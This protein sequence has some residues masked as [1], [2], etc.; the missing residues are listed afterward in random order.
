MTKNEFLNQLK[1]KI[2][3]LPKEERDNAIE[4]YEN[5][6][7]DAQ[8]EEEAIKNL[9]SVDE[10]AANLII[11][12]GEKK[13][14][15]GKKSGISWL[16]VLLAILSAPI[17]LPLGFAGLTLVFALI[18][19]AGFFI[20]TLFLFFIAFLLSGLVS[21]FVI[22]PA[23][24]LNFQTGCFF[25]G[26]FLSSTALAYFSLKFV[27]NMAKKCIIFIQKSISKL[28]RK[29]YKIEKGV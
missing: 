2:R 15:K 8:S 10:I 29:E 16:T 27:V 26:V 3:A 22:L 28:L 9:G 5:Y 12:F 11:E 18:I 7:A 20:F 25:L 13:R 14:E 24:L 4:F 6:F 19:T 21:I 23:F 17:T 1:R